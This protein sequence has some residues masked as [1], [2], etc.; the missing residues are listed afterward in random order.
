M[1]ILNRVQ[2]LIKRKPLIEEKVFG[3]ISAKMFSKK[4]LLRVINTCPD[5]SRILINEKIWIQ[6]NHLEVIE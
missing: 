3:E 4:D 2:S 5:G 6:V 1:S